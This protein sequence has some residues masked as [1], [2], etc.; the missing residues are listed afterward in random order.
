MVMRPLE[1][2]RER[3]RVLVSG[4]FCLVRSISN[5]QPLPGDQSDDKSPHSNEAL[6]SDSMHGHFYLYF[7]TR[8]ADE[9]VK[10]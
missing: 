4:L 8:R 2:K 9:W 1:T 5:T 3:V 7:L 6:E 10:T